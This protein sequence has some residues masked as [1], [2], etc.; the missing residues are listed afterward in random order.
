MGSGGLIVRLIDLVFI[1]LFGFIVIS[2]I[3]AMK[4]IEPPKSTEAKP[5]ENDSTQVII[6]GVRTNGSYP[7]DDGEV[8]MNDS[9]ELYHYLSHEAQEATAAGIPLGVRIR[10]NW[11]APVRFTM[12]AAMICKDLGLPKG[13]D[14]MRLVSKTD[15]HNISR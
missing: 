11:D 7:I 13:L 10:S 6:V 14:A 9:T 8:V 15:V 1:L 4:E 2:Q 3:T 5:Y 12:A